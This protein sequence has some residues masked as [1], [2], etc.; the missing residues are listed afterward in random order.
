MTQFEKVYIGKGKSL[1]NLPITRMTICIDDAEEFFS[2]YNGKMYLTFETAKMKEVDKFCRDTT[3]WVSRKF[4][5]PD[6]EPESKPKNKA[7]KTAK[8]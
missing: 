1:Q 8:A 3:C 6:P 2:H 4:E 7:K 5:T